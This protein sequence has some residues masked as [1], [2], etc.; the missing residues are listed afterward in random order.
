MSPFLYPD[1]FPA[2]AFRVRNTCGLELSSPP[3][4][5]GS[6]NARFYG[7]NGSE[8]RVAEGHRKGGSPFHPLCYSCTS[9]AEHPTAHNLRGKLV[10][11]GASWRAG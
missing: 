10:R 6:S 11:D 5:S 9:A 8:K 7:A 1:A 2:P 4:S 3:T